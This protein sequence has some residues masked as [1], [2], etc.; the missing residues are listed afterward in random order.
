MIPAHSIIT[1]PGAARPAQAPLPSEPPQKK[2]R[3]AHLIPKLTVGDFSEAS[4]QEAIKIGRRAKARGKPREGR[5]AKVLGDLLRNMSVWA[6]ELAPQYSFSEFIFASQALG[7]NRSLRPMLA[8]LRLAEFR[9]VNAEFEGNPSLDQCAVAQPA[10][11]DATQN[12]SGIQVAAEAPPDGID[13]IEWGNERDEWEE[14]E[15]MMDRMHME[16]TEPKRDTS[17]KTSEESIAVEV[18]SNV[19][20]PSGLNEGH[21]R[22]DSKTS[23]QQ[24]E[25]DS[26][27]QKE[28]IG[29]TNTDG[30]S[31]G[32]PIKDAITRVESK[33]GHNRNNDI[34]MSPV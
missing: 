4:L 9:E 13:A 8:N 34:P 25:S 27:Q 24:G 30:M 31:H 12:E 22:S 14:E 10:G 7:T 3:A 28:D 18:Q 2:Q 23:K 5:E 17:S 16:V 6:R 33:A 20:A 1:Q 11:R 26:R 32:Q 19:Q 15:A 29:K 21:Q